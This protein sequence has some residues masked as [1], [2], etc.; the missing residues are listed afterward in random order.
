MCKPQVQLTSATDIEEDGCQIRAQSRVLKNWYGCSV[1]EQVTLI[2]LYNQYASGQL[3]NSEAIPAE[4]AT[5]RVACSLGRNKREMV[6]VSPDVAVEEAVSTLGRFVYFGVEEQERAASGSIT[7]D[8]FE[9]LLQGARDKTFLPEN[10]NATNAKLSLKNVIIDWLAKN[11][12]GWEAVLAK[13][14]GLTFVSTLADAIW[15]VDGNEKTLA[16]RSLGIP[17]QLHQFQGYKQPEKHKHKVVADTMRASEL[18][19]HCM[20]LYS[21]WFCTPTGFVLPLVLYSHWFCTPTGF[22]LQLALYSHLFCT[23]TGFVLPLVLCIIK[24]V[25][26]MCNTIKY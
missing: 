9:I 18:R 25:S 12:L 13:H 24:I 21:N 3:D 14:V 11:K 8:A 16:D 15:Y 19:N 23:P 1:A 2:D 10:W 5:S 4:F 7:V 22:V 20:V 6:M 17:T 26:T